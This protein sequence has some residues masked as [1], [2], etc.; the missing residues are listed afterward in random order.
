VLTAVAAGD[1]AALGNVYAGLTF[2]DR[3][4]GGAV[5]GCHNAGGTVFAGLGDVWIRGWGS[6][7]QN[8]SPCYTAAGGMPTSIDWYGTPFVWGSQLGQPLGQGGALGM[9]RTDGLTDNADS[10]QGVRSYDSTAGVWTTPDAYAGVVDDPA[11]RKS[12]MWN[13]NN[14]VNYTDP[15]GYD[16]LQVGFWP[17]I[18]P[19]GIAL[20][21]HI[22][23]VLEDDFG[24]VIRVY[25]Y[26]PS[27]QKTADAPN[28]FLNKDYGLGQVF[29]ELF[30]GTTL[31]SVQ[32]ASCVGI[33]SWEAPFN[34]F[35]DDWKDNTTPYLG[36]PNTTNDL[37]SQVSGS[38][39]YDQFLYAGLPT[40]LPTGS[41][42][43][44]GG[45]G[46]P[47]GQEQPRADSG[48]GSSTQPYG[49]EAGTDFQNV[50][51]E[52]GAADPM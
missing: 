48:P 1:A 50:T 5:M 35:Y 49:G 16:S 27:D 19:A 22:Y 3:G 20:V 4:P 25:S 15:S 45:W 10:I 44:V 9:P 34:R 18:A 37:G 2:F 7:T 28:G 39:M 8:S 43:P 32:G 21:W 36:G 40:Q 29:D 6:Q 52:V 12:Y 11:S 46:L 41:P 38:A 14:P 17:A 13:G 26:G 42:F 47:S 30:A 24:N 31:Y 33:C 51:Q 23:A